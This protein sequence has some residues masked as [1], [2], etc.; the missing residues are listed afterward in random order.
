MFDQEKGLKGAVSGL[1]STMNR[2][3]LGPKDKRYGKGCRLLKGI[4]KGCHW[5]ETVLARPK[6]NQKART[7]RT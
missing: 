2:P 1:G 6:N 4:G 7:S 5:S 3:R